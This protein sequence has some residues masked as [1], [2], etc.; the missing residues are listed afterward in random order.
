MRRWEHVSLLWKV[1]AANV[2]VCVVATA[3]LAWT[4]ATVHPVA[5]SG[6]LVVLAIGLVGLLAVDRPHCGRRV[7][8]R[9]VGRSSA[10]PAA[11]TR[12]ISRH[13]TSPSG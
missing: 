6:E 5:T 13:S 9:D 2:V 10:E 8:G 3:L 12:V 4:P 1:F 7:Q 11:A